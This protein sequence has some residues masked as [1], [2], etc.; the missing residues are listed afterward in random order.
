[1]E[2]AAFGRITIDGEREEVEEEK[3]KVGRTGR[4]LGDVVGAGE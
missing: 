3:E 1:M 4:V 2:G